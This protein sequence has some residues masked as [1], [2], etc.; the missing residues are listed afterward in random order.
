MKIDMLIADCF[1]VWQETQKWVTIKR[2]EMEKRVR[3]EVIKDWKNLT[4]DQQWN[5]Q[6]LVRK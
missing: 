6:K 3:T 4:Y 2:S 1:I 5:D